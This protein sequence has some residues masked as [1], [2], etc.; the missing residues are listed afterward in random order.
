M[1]EMAVEARTRE[2]GMGLFAAARGRQGFSKREIDQRLMTWAM[3]D[4]Q[5]KV[6]LFRFVDVLPMLTDPEEVIEHLQAYLGTPGVAMPIF[7][8]LGQMGLRAVSGGGVVGQLLAST[9][10]SQVTGMARNFIAGA[11]LPEAV[12]VVQQLRK[13]QMAFTIDILGEVSVSEQEAEVY[14][15]QYLT[16]IDGLVSEAEHWAL[17]PRID[18]AEG[19]SIPKVNISLKLSA[20]CSQFE[21]AD[22]AGTAERVKARLRPILD[23]AQARGVFVNID[24][25]H[26]G[27]KDVTLRIF[28]EL[29]LEPAYRDWPHLGIVLQTYLRD[30]AED[31][32]A[33]LATVAARGAPITVRLVKGAYWDYE[34]IIAAQHRWP[35]PVF[36]QKYET[37]A[38]FEQ[39]AGL[40]LSE[41]PLVRLAVA[42]HNIRSIA[43]VM[44]R[45]E[46]LGLS[47]DTVEYQMLYGMG[48]QLK[49][50][51]LATGQRLRVYTPYGEL[52][53]GMAYL[54][55][56]LLENTANESFL[57]QGFAAR[58]APRQLL[59]NPAELGT[60]SSA[61]PATVDGFANVAER[62]F[63]LVGE[64]ERMVTALGQV[65]ER[66]GQPY[67]LLIGGK[68][69][70]TER[71]IIS[72]NPA[73]PLEVVGR[74]AAAGVDEAERAVA[75]ANAALP[76][77]RRTSAGARTGVLRRAADILEDERDELAAVQ[78]YEVGKNWR[79][80]DAD[81]CE[82]ID[83]LRYYADEMER[84]A[85]PRRLGRV[86]G[87]TNDYGYQSKGV[88][89]VLSPWNF[90]MA[91]FAGMTA[92]ALVTGNTAVVK[93]ASQSPVIA[94]RFVEALRRAGLPDGVVNFVPGSGAEIGDT[95]VTH[96]RVHLIAFTGS[97]AVGTR[98][99]RLAAEVPPGQ[100]HLKKVI[101]EM[102]GKNAIIVDSDAD[103]DEAVLGT[104]QSA[105]GY[106]G[107]KCSACSRVVV[108]EPVYTR[109]LERLVEAADSLRIGTPEDPGN[110]MGPVVDLQAQLQILKYIEIG[111]QEA[112]LAYQ[113]DVSSLDGYYVGPTIFTNIPANAT[114][115]QEEIFGPVLSVLLARDLTHALELANDVDYALT[116]GLYSRHPAHIEQVQQEFQVGNLYINRKITGAI[117][118]RQPFGGFRMSGIG[119]KAGG[120]D[121]LLQFM[122][123]VTVTENTLRRGFAP[124]ARG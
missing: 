123:P 114:I 7:G 69:V 107:Q 117:V 65:R 76:G 101:A 6:Q 86:P 110:F 58:I 82:T 22:P 74:V 66:L 13:Q 80:A 59:M 12:E 45:T 88:A 81:V 49:Q 23:L 39:M 25:E 90:P 8:Q 29:L 34:T 1:H 4:E 99:N 60:A 47:P 24:M 32:R 19:Q 50:A 46:A 54:V 77:W 67:P 18:M 10:R 3:R 2:I 53:P 79:E 51:V 116:G 106:Q 84:L 37:D 118:G 98:I 87:E 61:G 115:A 112:T 109:F 55:R 72:S 44:A 108:L 120:P 15:Q 28:R 70:T 42:S 83:Y 21:S 121:Y 78:V 20:L 103:L 104:V 94:A 124:E 119:S 113:R 11:N 95:L 105:F 41:Y 91:I 97:R 31:A 93:P 35:I 30:C 14:Q 57:R 33:L 96:P 64:Q 38:N 48:D 102:G 27:I 92:A 9:V 17:Q 75:A 16:L 100:R 89:V 43:A 111:K 52:I 40:L 36:T 71:E 62:N 5:F 56:R 85:P 63:A 73:R 122:D 26:Y 68:A